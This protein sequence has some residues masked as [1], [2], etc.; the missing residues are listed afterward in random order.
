MKP[1]PWLSISQ[2]HRSVVFTT[3]SSIKQLRKCAILHIITLHFTASFQA[4]G[5]P[6]SSGL[7]FRSFMLKI[8]VSQ[9]IIQVTIFSKVHIIC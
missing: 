1:F 4:I 6:G 7:Y 2:L 9:F 5:L 8:K 3:V